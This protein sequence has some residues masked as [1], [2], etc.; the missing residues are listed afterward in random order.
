MSNI[1]DLNRFN[2]E[3][4]PEPEG[5]EPLRARIH[6]LESGATHL[7]ILEVILPELAAAGRPA[8][9]VAPVE[10]GGQEQAALQDS[11]DSRAESARLMAQQAISPAGEQTP[12]AADAQPQYVEQDA[13]VFGLDRADDNTTAP[14]AEDHAA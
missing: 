5:L 7:R 9:G 8:A 4:A 2:G 11:A 10:R 3:R 14:E 1:L 13:E 6:L 12:S